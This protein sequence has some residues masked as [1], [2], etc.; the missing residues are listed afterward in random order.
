VGVGE[1][2]TVCYGD[3]TNSDLLVDY[4]FM[5]FR[6]SSKN[7]DAP[8]TNENPYV[9]DGSANKFNNVM[10]RIPDELFHT[11]SSSRRAR[12]ECLSR[13][14][15]QQPYFQCENQSRGSGAPVSLGFA[16]CVLCCSDRE[17]EDVLLAAPH[18]WHDVMRQSSS[19]LTQVVENVVKVAL[20]EF[21]LPPRNVRSLLENRE[22]VLAPRLL[23]AVMLVSEEQH[24]WQDIRE[25]F[26]VTAS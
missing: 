21:C 6:R 24:M 9:S 26:L 1:E 4:G 17:F 2:F 3:K 18:R 22:V 13:F 5:L 25:S 15:V 16:L 7:D 11:P 10:F 19:R 12:L 23:Q 14:G 20:G 8:A